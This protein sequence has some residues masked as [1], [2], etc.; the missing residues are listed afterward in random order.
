MERE[1]G[2]ASGVKSEG[3]ICYLENLIQRMISYLPL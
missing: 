1:N 3:E 2:T